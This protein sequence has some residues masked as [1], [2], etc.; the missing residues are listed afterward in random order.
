MLIPRVCRINN[1]EAFD[2][3]RWTAL[4]I[5]RAGLDEH[6]PLD[7]VVVSTRASPAP[8]VSGVSCWGA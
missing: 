8:S 6:Q 2:V 7:A 5:L 3:L 1:R 4:A